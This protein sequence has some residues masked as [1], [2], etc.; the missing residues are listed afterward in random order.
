MDPRAST[1][2]FFLGAIVETSIA[3]QQSRSRKR[4]V[5]TGSAPFTAKEVSEASIPPKMRKQWIHKSY[6]TLRTS[7]GQD[8]D[9]NQTDAMQVDPG[10]LLPQVFLNL[11][12]NIIRFKSNATAAASLVSSNNNQRIDFPSVK[13]RNFH[14]PT[15]SRYFTFYSFR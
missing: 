6:E 5:T 13:F 4:R 1:S 12:S 7:R 14:I 11:I 10:E 8:V 9:L 15:E 3:S 2:S